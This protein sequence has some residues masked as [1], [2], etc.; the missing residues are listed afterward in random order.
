MKN[1]KFTF[2]KENNYVYDYC[3]HDKTGVI[4]FAKKGDELLSLP[5]Y[6]NI[7]YKLD[8]LCKSLTEHMTYDY[9]LIEK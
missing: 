8:E 7:K 6:E 9:E 1:K 4:F 5:E 2:V 3:L